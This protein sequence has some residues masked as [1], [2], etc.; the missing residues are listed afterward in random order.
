MKKYEIS[1]DIS[2]NDMT[3]NY[4]VKKVIKVN[5]Q[6]NLPVNVDPEQYIRSRMAEEVKRQFKNLADEI[7]N[8]TEDFDAP[9]GK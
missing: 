8:K 4:D 9:E 2:V 5:V 7:D 1:F 6:E 3:L